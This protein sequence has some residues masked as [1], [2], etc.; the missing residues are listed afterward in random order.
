MDSDLAS[1]VSVVEST[2]ESLDHRLY[3]NGQPGDIKLIHDK[4]DDLRQWHWKMIGALT[5]LSV[6]TPFLVEVAKKS[7]G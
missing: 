4:L 3:G 5:L 6:V 2:V 7:F 1:R